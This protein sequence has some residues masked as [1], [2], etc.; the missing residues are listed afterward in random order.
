[1]RCVT[2]A[3]IWIDLDHGGLL[4]RVF[5]LGCDLL[6]PDL[7]FAEL[8]TPDTS[9]LTSLG[10]QVVGL[11][12]AQLG[13]LTTTL[14]RAYP[15]P[16]VV[17]LTALVVARDEKLVLLTGDKALRQAAKTEGVEVHGI[18]WILDWMVAG[19]VL[20]GVE[21][22]RSLHLIVQAGARLPQREVTRRL[23]LWSS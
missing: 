17:D 16:S 9:L 20:T 3:N 2:D 21:A 10:L 8:R 7:I 13:D 5:N 19:S 23:R 18:L 12:G 15:K 22:A 14:A 4:G 6:I 11:T 1:M